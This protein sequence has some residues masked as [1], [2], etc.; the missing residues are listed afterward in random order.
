MSNL[1]AQ[2]LG[3]FSVIQW[4]VIPVLFIWFRVQPVNKLAT[5]LEGS[6]LPTINLATIEIAMIAN[7]EILAIC[8][9]AIWSLLVITWVFSKIFQ[10]TVIRP[11]N[12][13]PYLF[14]NL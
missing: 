11:S 6:L 7:Q 12:K 14:S 2:V 1:V 3:I 10:T 13:S 5:V 9:T 4:I 8:I